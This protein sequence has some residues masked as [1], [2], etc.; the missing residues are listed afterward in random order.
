ME[1]GVWVGEFLK[2]CKA[3]SGCGKRFH[4]IAMIET[5][6]GIGENDEQQIGYSLSGK[7]WSKR[8]E[9]KAIANREGSTNIFIYATLPISV[10][11][12]VLD[13]QVRRKHTKYMY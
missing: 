9:K 2:V 8:D 10:A 3:F 7:K 12:Y 1:T 4:E 6:R 5:W 13:V 11:P